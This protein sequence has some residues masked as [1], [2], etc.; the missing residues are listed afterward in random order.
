MDSCSTAAGGTYGF[1]AAP[2][3]GK[4]MAELIDTGQTP[5]LIK[6]FSLDRFKDGRLVNEKGAA[7]SAALH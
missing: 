4:M 1:K 3:S 6:P 5:D 7:S 2:I